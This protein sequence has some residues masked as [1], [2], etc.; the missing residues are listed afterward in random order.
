M[1]PSTDEGYSTT[2]A[3]VDSVGAPVDS[4][5]APVD[6][7][8]APVDS[9]S[10]PV[11]SASA[12]ADENLLRQ[13][14]PDLFEQVKGLSNRV[15]DPTVLENI[16][17]KLCAWR[18]LRSADLVSILGKTDKYLLRNFITPLREAGKLQYVHP[19]MPNHPQQA[20][21]T[22]LDAVD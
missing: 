6:S 19:E 15:N 18:P 1:G 4:A 10:A 20:Y 2:S 21:R 8:G 5:S 13:L 7:V 12:P 22:I 17:L 14:P 16:I 11:D 3:P 9:A